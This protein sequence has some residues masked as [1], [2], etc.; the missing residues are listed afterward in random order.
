MGRARLRASTGHRTSTAFPCLTFRSERHR[1]S[2]PLW[3]SCLQAQEKY[4]VLVSARNSDNAQTAV[5]RLQ[6]EAADKTALAPL[7][8][9][10]TDDSSIEPAAK[11]VSGQFGHLGI[12]INN[13][14]TG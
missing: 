8:L 1:V 14:S 12:L 6:K 13:A 4:H 3:R 2:A 9:D 5:E 10:V 11:S 7:I